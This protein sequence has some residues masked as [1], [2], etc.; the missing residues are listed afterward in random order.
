[1]MNSQY[2]LI[3]IPITLLFSSSAFYVDSH[4]NTEEIKHDTK[5]LQY[6]EFK[7][8]NVKEQEETK[9]KMGPLI[10]GAIGAAGG[11][12][13]SIASDV[14]A[15]QSVN[16]TNAGINAGAGFVTGATGG[17]LGGVSGAIAGTVP[18]VSAYGGLNAAFA[19]GGG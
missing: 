16:W 5:A 18:G 12:A 17:F 19:G 11:G 7:P 15:D 4:A 14:M 2:L 10:A 6:D 9:G 8:L 1:M 13:M 3:I